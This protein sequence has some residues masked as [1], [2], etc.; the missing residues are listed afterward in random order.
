MRLAVPIIVAIAGIAPAFAQSDPIDYSTYVPTTELYTA[1]ETPPE[2]ALVQRLFTLA[3]TEACSAAIDGGFGG[4]EPQVFDFTYR[5]SY[6]EPGDEDRKF[7][8]YQFNCNGGAYN[9]SSAFYGW[10]EV[11]GLEP[12]SFATPNAKPTYE[13]VDDNP[14]GKLVSLEPGGIGSRL[15]M[16]NAEVDEKTGEIRSVGYWRGIGDASSSGVWQLVDGEYSLTS[17]DIDASYDGEVNPVRVYP[18]VIPMHE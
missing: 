11:S 15:L 2:T 12:I 10:D 3:F 9:F 8:L 16:S 1:N 5:D 18:L 7:R 4:P 14:D 13:D 17:Y 6:A